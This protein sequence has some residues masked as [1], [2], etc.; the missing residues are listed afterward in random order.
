MIERANVGQR[1]I[2][3]GLAVVFGAFLLWPPS[4]K[5]R[6]GLD[7]AGGTSLIFEIDD[8]DTQ[9]DPMLAE[10]VKTLLQK[11]VDPAG[12]YNLTWRV[13]GRNRIE[14][15]MPLPPKDA[16]QRQQDYRDALK[17]L[18]S[19]ELGRGELEQALRQ[20]GAEREAALQKL[21]KRN[22]DQ[23]L[24]N[25]DPS[26]SG[27]KTI[28]TEL[29]AQRLEKLQRAAER[30]DEWIAAQD[31]L[32]GATTTQPTTNPADQLAQDELRAAV[33]DASELYEDAVDNV[34]SMNIN[35]GRFEEILEL[36][37]KS[38]VRQKSL[39][40]IE[41]AQ[42][43]IRAQIENVIEKHSIWHDGKRFLDG[44]GDLK[45][46]LRGAGKLEFRILAQPDPNNPTKFNRYRERLQEA[47]TELAGTGFGWFR[48]DNAMQFFNFD[49]PAEL[50][51][52]DH[53]GHGTYVLGKFDNNYYVL[54]KTSPQDGL[55]Q[56]VQGQ[57]KWRLNKARAV[58]DEHGHWSVNFELDV[59]GGGMFYALTSRN[60]KKQLCILVDDVA[61]SAPNI[62]TAIRS[63]GRITGQFSNQKVSYLVQTMEGG[64]LPARL[65]ET[66]LSERT[67]GSSLGETNRDRAVSAGL[68]GG[69]AVILIML[70]YYLVAG[71]VAN[72]ALFLNIFF[73]LSI[74]A[75]LGARITLVGIAGVI[76]SVGMAVDANV[77]IF[78]RMREE[79][80]RGASLRMIIKNGY[81]KA[82]STI[83]DSNI[84]TLLTC[85]IIYY[86]GSEEVKGFGLTLGWG[87]VLNLFTSIFV[88][89]TLFLL[90]L[91]FNLIKDIKMMRIIGVPNIDW[92]AKRK[93]FLP[94]SLA[95]MIIGLSLLGMRGTKKTLDVE[96]LGGV[97][98]EFAV[99]EDAQLDDVAINNA[100]D[101][102]AAEIAAAGDRLGEATV[103]PIP[104]E[105]NSYAV[106]IPDVSSE[107]LAAIIAEPLEDLELRD[108]PG[109]APAEDDFRDAEMAVFK[110]G[111][112]E[113]DPAGSDVRLYPLTDIDA[114]SLQQV[115]R[116]LATPTRTAAANLSEANVN[117]VLE[118]GGVEQ[119]GSI[120]NITTTV[121]NMRLVQHALEK[122]LGDDMI[123]QPQIS[124]VFRGRGSEP[125]PVDNRLL[126]E[127]VPDLPAGVNATVTDYLGGAAF[128]FEQ[129]DPPASV[130]QLTTR[131]DNMHFQPDF[132]DLPKRKFEVIGIKPVEGR[133]DDDGNQLY[134][135]VAVV[136][137][138]PDVRYGV[139][140]DVWL[141][142]LAQPERNLIETAL[143]TE[144]TLRKVMRFKPQIA[145]R[146]TQQAATALLLS[147]A[148][149][150]GYL[151]IRFGR[152]TYGIAGVAA[153][154]HDV[155]IALAFVGISGWIGGHDHP[156]GEAL[157]ISDFKINMT[158]IA[159]LLTIIGYSINDTI[160]VFDRIRETRGRLGHVTPEIVNASINQTLSRTIMTSLTT[161]V[162]LL[163]MYIWG[164]S[165]IRGFNF[166]MM[167]GVITG[168]Y[169]SIAV[170][171]PLLLARFGRFGAAAPAP[172][173]A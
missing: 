71:A 18:Y 29:V 48:I 143:S 80:E 40:Q 8:S 130:P 35:R 99:N 125:F 168:S 62:E 155:L 136:T 76:L 140:R 13:H 78:E 24:A 90:L 38:D 95:I 171:S 123:V 33:R 68:I 97:T 79:K 153:L 92:Y 58:R 139:D 30:Y 170:A 128:V 81:D 20:D 101:A 144:Q 133:V 53:L 10:R 19:Y 147:W 146:S 56:D 120:W 4:Q 94:I 141:A 52:F 9:N 107:R 169:S 112:I 5:L 158:I 108:L 105:V 121:T 65:K 154:I 110:R 16:K 165:S 59:I 162:V 82:L 31:A 54:A 77:L 100:I 1:L 51:T 49:S 66:P 72:V 119:S 93:I 6:P 45:R 23:A 102:V 167:I 91:R 2:I 161:F 28:I 3:I 131:L 103:A 32:A 114:D 160:V 173:T 69:A 149:I 116:G 118:V 106:R 25:L 124:Y 159:A 151:W 164:G 46:L 135:G 142:S 88:T 34:L 64:M 26:E 150:I 74:M 113:A 42:A 129:L 122:A 73:L 152:P 21:A 109:Y 83:F 63:H 96:F 57:R 11:R 36:D 98:A 15:Q 172:R 156:M 27:Q 39:A 84:T 157:L 148:M 127:V 166:C 75:M 47:D 115:I 134:Q 104:G 89:R 60:I 163:I 7:I 70:G 17:E 55:L 44:P 117:A 50:D 145:S 85:V 111:N 61:Y 132:Q 138:D 22:A 41:D 12:V 126:D 37:A 43:D 86:V 137:V 87:I 67:V 14:V